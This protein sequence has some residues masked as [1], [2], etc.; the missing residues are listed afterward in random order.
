MTFREIT[1]ADERIRLLPGGAVFL[2]DTKTLVVADLHLG[3]GTSAR[4][5]GLLLPPGDTIST[6]E[7][8]LRFVEAHSPQLLISLGDSFHD[9]QAGGRLLDSERTLLDRITRTADTL[10]ITGN[11]DALPISG[12]GGEWLEEYR[13][14]NL[15]L[16]HIPSVTIP[17]GSAELAGHLHP[18]TR[19][20]SRGHVMSR[21]CFL[22]GEERLILPALGTYTGGLDISNSV[23]SSLFKHKAA[24]YVWSTDEI[25]RVA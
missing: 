15:F 22:T 21:P 11:H 19:I 10:W 7:K 17:S 20:Q 5:R 18:K 2:P 12:I 25:H 4:A 6:L 16:R 24:A 23:L 1:L 14:G 9:C 13:S 3:K 8:V